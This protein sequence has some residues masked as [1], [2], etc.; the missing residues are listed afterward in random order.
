[1]TSPKTSHSIWVNSVRKRDEAMMILEKANMPYVVTFA[2][3][4]RTLPQNDRQW[5]LLAIIARQC[6]WPDFNGVMRKMT[7]ED[8][9]LLFMAALWKETR[10]VPAID[11][12]GFV[13]LRRSSSSNLTKEENSDLQALIEAFAAK[14][15]ISINDKKDAA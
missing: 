8:W 12:E 1:M 4:K 9:K 15:G 7:K 6:E 11:G 2:R 5:V 14:N 10:V 13:S 3:E